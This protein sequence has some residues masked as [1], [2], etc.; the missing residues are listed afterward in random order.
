M[1]AFQ[2]S[3]RETLDHVHFEANIWLKLLVLGFFYFIKGFLAYANL[4]TLFLVNFANNYQIITY[5]M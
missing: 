5:E 4:M 1:H 3:G 2:N